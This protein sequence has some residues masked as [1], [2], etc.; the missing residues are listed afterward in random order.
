[1]IHNTWTTV[2]SGGA[3]VTVKVHTPH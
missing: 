1:L 3:S 2:S